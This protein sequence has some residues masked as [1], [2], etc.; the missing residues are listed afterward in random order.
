MEGGGGRERER[1]KKRTTNSWLVF[2][3]QAQ[4]LGLGKQHLPGTK[5]ICMASFPPSLLKRDP[6]FFPETIDL[7]QV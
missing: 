1:E 6:Q 5:A 2:L 7:K 3:L 4:T